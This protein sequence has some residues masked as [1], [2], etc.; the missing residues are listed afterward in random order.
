MS[1]TL[2]QAAL[3]GAGAGLY[4]HAL[5]RLFLASF[6]PRAGEAHFVFV[7]IGAPIAAAA[8]YLFCAELKG[9]K[10]GRR[11][12]P[13]L[14]WGI[15]S[16]GLLIV[17]ERAFLPA[18]G[19]EA[20]A[21]PVFLLLHI[22]APAFAAAVSLLAGCDEADPPEAPG[23]F[24]LLLGAGLLAASLLPCLHP[25]TAA[26]TGAVLGTLSG[27]IAVSP[28]S[29]AMSASTQPSLIPWTICSSL[30]GSSRPMAT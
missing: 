11:G 1:A 22:S 6:W 20:V 30:A 4:F 8:V 12:W 15:S 3:L 16:L 7:L 23:V 10:G 2:L 9:G 27:M 13:W 24:L 29:R 25:R 14:G 19:V 26:L 18:K 5:H 17:L 21:L 28:P